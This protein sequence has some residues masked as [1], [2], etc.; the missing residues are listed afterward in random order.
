V[1]DVNQLPSVGPGQVLGD[2][3]DSKQIPVVSLTEIFRQ[4]RESRIITNAHRINQGEFPIVE[5]PTDPNDETDFY[6]IEQED[7]QRVLNTIIELVTRRIPDRFGLQPMRDIQVLTPM[8]K[9]IVGAENLNTSLQQALNPGDVSISRGNNHFRPYDKVM[10]IKNNY[11][12]LVFNG[13][14][15]CIKKINAHD[16][17]VLISF[18]GRDIVYEYTELS[19][20]VLAYAISVHKSQG[21]EYPAVVLPVLTQHY[22][23]LQRNLIYTA[24]TRGKTLVVVVGTRKALHIGINNSKT[25]KR[26]TQLKRRLSD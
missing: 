20:V 6:F 18:D 5:P 24:V 19:E 16:Q 21:S 13:D 12:K 11:D 23:L 14:I 4:A 22:I 10:Q 1:G 15:G 7:P 3:M 8:H 17:T 25:K 2:M 26:F 9:G